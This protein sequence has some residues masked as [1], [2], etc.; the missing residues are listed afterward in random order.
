M[1]G[2]TLGLSGKGNKERRA[3]SKQGSQPPHLA[4]GCYGLEK[5]HL[6]AFFQA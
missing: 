5:L 2:M 4:A 3:K 6:R 1:H